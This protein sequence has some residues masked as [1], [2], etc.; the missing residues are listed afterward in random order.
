MKNLIKI[1][2]IL[3]IWFISVWVVNAS[4]TVCLKIDDISLVCKN[5][6][7]KIKAEKF[8]E[9]GV[10]AR[11]L[12]VWIEK[13][14]QELLNSSLNADEREEIE[15]NL[16]YYKKQLISQRKDFLSRYIWDREYN[17]FWIKPD[18]RMKEHDK[19]QKIRINFNIKYWKKLSNILKKFN[20]KKLKKIYSLINIKKQKIILDTKLSRSKKNVKIALYDL[21]LY[22]IE[23]IWAVNDEDNV[24]KWLGEEF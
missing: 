17:S 3:V 9:D 19:M 8:I 12:K 15:N 2:V 13:K 24:L 11:S 16:K 18:I 7:E 5:N 21:I 4:F 22:K 20:T 23:D 6:Q 10:N 14:E 1:L